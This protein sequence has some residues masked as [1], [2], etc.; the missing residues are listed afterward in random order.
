MVLKQLISISISKEHFSTYGPLKFH[1]RQRTLLEINKRLQKCIRYHTH[2]WIANKCH[3]E[4]VRERPSYIHSCTKNINI[5]K[6]T[7]DRG[8]CLPDLPSVIKEL[9][10]TDA[11][12][13]LED[14]PRWSAL[15]E[16]GLHWRKWPHCGCIPYPGKLT[17]HRWSM[18]GYTGPGPLNHLNSGQLW[19]ELAMG[20]GGNLLRLNP[21][22]QSC[23]LLPST[24][25]DPNKI[26]N[27]YF[28]LKVSFPGNPTFNKS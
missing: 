21:F 24:G 23:F 13:L 27:A 10:P 6:A 18:R 28:C 16:N 2:S 26:L 9:F 5:L 15:F 25:V 4:I 22:A 1:G 3:R 12:I 7:V 11:G 19:R 8:I 20:L 14:N 17:T